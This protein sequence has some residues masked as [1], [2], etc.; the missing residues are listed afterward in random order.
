[1]MRSADQWARMKPKAVLDGSR[2]QSLYALIDAQADIA[3]LWAETQE[4]RRFVQFVADCS[5]DPGIRAEAIKL[6]AT[7]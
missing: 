7:S 4:L 1:M 3:N 2:E 5:N 6:G